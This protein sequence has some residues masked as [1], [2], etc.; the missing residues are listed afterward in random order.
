MNLDQLHTA[1][2]QRD[3]A[4]IRGLIHECPA[5]LLKD[6]DGLMSYAYLTNQSVIPILVDEG[7][8]VDQRNSC[9]GTVLACAA[10]NGD[11]EMVR[12]LLEHGADVN[13]QN[14]ERETP[15]S[16][17]CAYDHR[18]VAEALRHHGA[19]INCVHRAG[20]TPLDN[21]CHTPRIQK[22]LISIG[23]KRESEL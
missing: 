21:R 13:A 7:V 11:L 2:E 3:A 23:A 12:W 15:F 20:G 18:E 14:D 22:F 5:D 1:I 10:S 9:N 4:V 8:D 17:A 16:F 19:N 6:G